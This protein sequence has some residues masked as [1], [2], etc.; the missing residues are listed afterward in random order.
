MN[1]KDGWII[2]DFDCWH[3]CNNPKY[4]PG[5]DESS[6]RIRI[7]KEMN[8]KFNFS[9]FKLFKKYMKIPCPRCNKVGAQKRCGWWAVDSADTKLQDYDGSMFLPSEVQDYTDQ[10]MLAKIVELT[11]E[12]EASKERIKSLKKDLEI[13]EKTAYISQ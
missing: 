1:K 10:V 4:S 8:D 2:V 6:I 7:N 3:G 5:C 9:L 12:I 13:I 11:E